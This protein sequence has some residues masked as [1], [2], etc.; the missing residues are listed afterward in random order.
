M[1]IPLQKDLPEFSLPGTIACPMCGGNQI[2]AEYRATG[3]CLHANYEV[4]ENGQL[5]PRMHRTCTTCLYAWDE[6]TLFNSPSALEFR[7]RK[8]GRYGDSLPNL[9][10]NPEPL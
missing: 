2:G 7:A 3:V 6:R 10:Q 8:G 4:L 9:L 5:N 1:A